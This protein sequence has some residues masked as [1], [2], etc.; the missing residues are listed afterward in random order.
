MKRIAGSC[1]GG[2]ASPAWTR[3]TILTSGRNRLYGS[4]SIARCHNCP[5]GDSRGRLAAGGDEVLKDDP[6]LD[7]KVTLRVDGLGV[8]S[9]LDQLSI[10]SGVTLTAGL[11]D[12]DW[13]VRDRKLIVQVADM[14]LVDLMQLISQV[15]H[16]HWSKGTVDGK[17]TYR[18]WQD[19]QEFSEEES[20]RTAG[21]SA[22]SKEGRDKR[23]NALA[24]M[25]NLGSLSAADA[26]RLRAGDPWRYV[27]ATEPLGR[28]VAI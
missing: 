10:S 26:A 14:R 18:L 20:L 4:A 22:Q 1:A 7:Q 5:L 17:A 25:T 28:D 16:F 27:L 11:N 21:D 24:D 23:E 13:S 2:M 3:K 19:K 15:L 12:S 8:S 6:R 9:V